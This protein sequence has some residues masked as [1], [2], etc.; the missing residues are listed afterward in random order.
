MGGSFNKQISVETL[1]AGT[2][3]LGT[4]SGGIAQQSI[5]IPEQA[6]LWLASRRGHGPCEVA[7]DMNE[8]MSFCRLR[9]NN[10]SLYQRIA[11][12]FRS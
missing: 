5:G 1:A 10:K 8:L 2:T 3:D 6:P 7:R 12:H 11:I 4:A 9:E